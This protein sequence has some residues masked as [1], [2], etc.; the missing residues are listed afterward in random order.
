MSDVEEIMASLA[1]ESSGLR[2]R[3]VRDIGSFTVA[4]FAV[5]GA[6]DGDHLSLAGTGTLLVAI[7]DSH[8]IL[9]A[10]HVWEE[11]LRPAPMVGITLKENVDHRSLM[12]TSEIVAF[13]L[14]K[15]DTWGEWGPDLAFLRVPHERVGSISV[16]RV[17]YSLT[18]P[19]QSVPDVEHVETLV[20]MGTPAALGAF[21]QTHADLEIH[22]LFMQVDALPRI[23]GNL[24]YLDFD[25]DVSFPGVPEEFGGVSGGGLWR[26][27]IYRSP[28][29]G[30]IDWVKPLEGVAFHQ[31][32]LSNGHRMIRCHGPH[33]I[34][35]SMPSGN[36]S[37]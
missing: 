14:Q 17:F 33:S 13:G 37:G 12:K 31:S 11:V 9:T 5:S 19:R 32:D 23:H 6:R 1:E 27:Q 36:A 10:A 35:A 24:D 28:S 26:I 34:R 30:E 7:A 20:L 29:T 8:F 18:K 15:P 22:G 16:Y 3:I 25:V 4:L 2:D 21:T